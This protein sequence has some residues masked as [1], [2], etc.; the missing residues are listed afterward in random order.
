MI[1]RFAIPAAIVAF[2]AVAAF[3]ATSQ[4]KTTILEQQRCITSN[5]I[6]D[7][8]TGKFPNAHNPNSIRTQNTN[9]CIP[10]SPDKGNKATPVRTTGI[11]LNGVLIRPGTAGHYDP[12]ARKGHS[13]R[14]VSD[15]QVEGMFAGKNLGIDNNNAHVDKRGL[16][17][18]HGVPPTLIGVNGDTQIAWAAD[19]FPIHYIGEQARPSYMLKS[20]TRPKG[21]KDPGGAYDGTYVQDWEYERG[22]GN[23]DEC[24]GAMLGDEYVYFVTDAY[25]FYPRCLYGTRI[26]NIR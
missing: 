4:I 21:P 12:N 16:Y 19:G 24:N 22:L 11:A 15:W 3:A 25:P 5:G 9:V 26:T 10:L 17:H 13:Q 1:L 18:Y 14:P 8:S 2:T 6:P 23:L 20:G 7:H